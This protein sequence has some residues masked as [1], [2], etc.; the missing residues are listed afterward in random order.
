MEIG[1]RNVYLNTSA[2]QIVKEKRRGKKQKKNLENK[3]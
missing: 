2:M 3:E 1:T